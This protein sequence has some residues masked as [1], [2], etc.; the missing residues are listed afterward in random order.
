[1]TNPQISDNLINSRWKGLM[2]L[3]DQ[4]IFYMGGRKH[5]TFA[6]VCGVFFFF[7]YLKTVNL[8]SLSSVLQKNVVDPRN[9]HLTFN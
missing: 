1:M 6:H 2:E 7:F 4:G 5:V 3:N 9:Y 8:I